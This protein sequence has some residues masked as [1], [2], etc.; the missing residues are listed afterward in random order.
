MQFISFQ[1]HNLKLLISGGL[2]P[3]TWSQ[4]GK[5]LKFL[6]KSKQQRRQVFTGCL[7]NF[8]YRLPRLFW[9]FAS[10]PWLHGNIFLQFFLCFYPFKIRHFS[11]LSTFWYFFYNLMFSK[12][13]SL[14]SQ[15]FYLSCLT[16]PWISEF[17]NFPDLA[18]TFCS[19]PWVAKFVKT[20]VTIDQYYS[21]WKL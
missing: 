13:D 21:E 12:R 4:N 3:L 11:D 16:F 17:P 8:R 15:T 20:I 7:P 18:D 10:F 19:G 14:T 6:L 9:L 5:T 1:I 2:W